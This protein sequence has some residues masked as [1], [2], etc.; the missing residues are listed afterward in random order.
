MPDIFQ[1][2]AESFG[3]FRFHFFFIPSDFLFH[4]VVPLSCYA[5]LIFHLFGIQARHP[6]RFNWRRRVTEIDSGGV[7]L[8]LETHTNMSHPSPLKALSDSSVPTQKHV[9]YCQSQSG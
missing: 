7:V 2:E 1:S 3:L 5:D 9:I 4:F 6:G 8:L